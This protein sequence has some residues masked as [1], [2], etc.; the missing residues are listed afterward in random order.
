MSAQTPDFAQVELR[1][2]A[3]RRK[4]FVTINLYAFRDW[5]AAW[6]AT[7]RDERKRKIRMALRAEGYG[8][9]D[10]PYA[11]A[12]GDRAPS[13]D[14]GEMSRAVFSRLR[15]LVPCLALTLGLAFAYALIAPKSYTATMSLLLDPRERVPAGVDAAPMPQN[16][17]PA[18]VE[19]QMR[20]MTSQIVLLKVVDEQRLADEPPGLIGSLFEVVRSITGA[21]APTAE[22]R[23]LAAAEKLAKSV[24]M[25]R[26]ERNYVIDVEVKG[27]TRQKALALAQALADAYLA[28]KARLTDDVSD[29][30]RAAIDRKLNDLRVRVEVA[31]RNAQDYR[32][33]HE[34]VVSEG[35]S[36]PEQRLKDANSALVVAHG[37][38]ADLEARYA[39]IKAT[40]AAGL[41]AQTVNEDLRSPVIEK[42]R[43]DYAALARDEA[44]AQ[45]VLGP[46]HPSYLTIQKQMEST[47]AQIR[48]EQHR[49]AQATERELK[50]AREA[51]RTAT[52]LVST[53]EISTNKVGD[54][55]VELN[56]LDRAASALRA[57]YEKALAA[58]ETVR[59]DPISA[60][61]AMLISPPSAPMSPSSPKTLAAF[62]IAF[63]AGVNLWIAAALVAEYRHRRGASAAPT[64]PREIIRPTSLGAA[65]ASAK[66][67]TPPSRGDHDIPQLPRPRGAPA[68]AGPGSVA[69]AMRAAGPYR[70]EI[71]AL[72]DSLLDALAASGRTPFVLVAGA[73]SGSGASTIALS[74]AH[75]ACNR[76]L[77]AL[78]IDRNARAPALSDFADDF[79]PATLRRSGARARILRRDGDGEILLQPLNAEDGADEGVA[80]DD[81]AVDL[82]LIDAGQFRAA[83]RLAQDTRSI[84]AMVAVARK[85]A[86]VARVEDDLDRLGLGDLCVALALTA[87]RGRS[88]R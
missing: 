45:S 40:L 14:I 22:V 47:R 74:L 7:R 26:S 58:R 20:L 60:P 87:A 64:R 73:A 78:V 30:E 69:P 23:R 70:V 16:P 46:R 56:D 51:E 9:F 77:R 44:Y 21:A 19:S 5:L 29:R 38:R 25:K 62:L 31:E 52:K 33:K 65:A 36:S 18:L 55:R 71:D 54:K 85:G 41:D 13:M 15:L 37:K 34:L 12:G 48:A 75:A 42:L 72:F 63:V 76:G 66:L 49:I 24:S 39:Q 17:D 10:R 3:R 32:D 88:L 79:E 68:R 86:D 28:A 59:R 4:Q 57:S 61:L 82:V 43:S 1:W 35:R 6:P 27:R 84:D 50:T 53:L 81:D 2:G 80:C 8:S 83:A 67:W 11:T